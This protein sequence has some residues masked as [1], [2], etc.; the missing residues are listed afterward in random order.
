MLGWM[1][2]W[3]AVLG[4]KPGD[5]KGESLVQDRKKRDKQRH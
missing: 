3:L 2:G 5:L 1:L 4:K